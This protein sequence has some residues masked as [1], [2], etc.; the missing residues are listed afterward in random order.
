MDVSS[1]LAGRGV[2]GAEQVEDG[3]AAIAEGLRLVDKNDERIYEAEL[4]RIK[5]QLTLQ[6]EARGW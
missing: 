2:W 5:G 4:Y 3:L 6:Q 1:L